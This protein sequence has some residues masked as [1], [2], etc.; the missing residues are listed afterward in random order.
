MIKYLLNNLD[1]FY[2]C[3]LGQLVSWLQRWADTSVT[4]AFGDAQIIPPYSRDETD[5]TDNTDVTGDTD[6]KVDT[7]YM[8]IQIIQMLQMIQE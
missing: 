6:D 2:I 3:V 4:L 1:R 7:A 5:D 8:L